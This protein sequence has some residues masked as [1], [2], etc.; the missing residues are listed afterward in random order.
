MKHKVTSLESPNEPLEIDSFVLGNYTIGTFFREFQVEISPMGEIKQHGRDFK[1]YDIPLINVLYIYSSE[2]EKRK[3]V[4]K[5]FVHNDIWT[6]YFDGPR[7][8]E[9][10]GVGYV[11]INPKG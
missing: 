7:L 6:L 3:I 9:G 2:K 11:L 5:S 8:Q 1:K 4:S 10:V